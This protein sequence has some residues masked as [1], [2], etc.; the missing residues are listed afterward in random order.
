MKGIDKVED[1]NYKILDAILREYK[2]R[3]KRYDNISKHKFK[4][5]YNNLSYLN[6]YL[7]LL[8]HI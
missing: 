6:S 4:A 8:L 2:I 5:K 7:S 3:C 1:K